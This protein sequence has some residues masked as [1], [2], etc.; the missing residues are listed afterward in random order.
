MS[1]DALSLS[2]FYA[3]RIESHHFYTFALTYIYLQHGGDHHKV[4]TSIEGVLHATEAL[5]YS[6]VACNTLG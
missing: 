2:K 6:Y 1:H 5:H 4:L 3:R